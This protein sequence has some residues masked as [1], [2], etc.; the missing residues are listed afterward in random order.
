[1]RL[2]TLSLG[3]GFLLKVTCFFFVIVVAARLIVF[4]VGEEFFCFSI[5]RGTSKDASV[6]YVYSLMHSSQRMQ[7]YREGI[8]DPVKNSPSPQQGRT[9]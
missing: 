5:M 9:G 2:L 8:Q 6:N 7:G 4:F 1:M 3:R